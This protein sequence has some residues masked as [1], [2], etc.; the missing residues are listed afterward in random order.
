MLTHAVTF[1]QGTLLSFVLQYFLHKLLALLQMNLIFLILLNGFSVVNQNSNQIKSWWV[2]YRLEWPQEFCFFTSLASVW[3]Y[4]K[5]TDIAHK[6]SRIFSLNIAFYTLSKTF[7]GQAQYI[8]MHS[9][10]VMGSSVKRYNCFFKYNSLSCE[11][12][13]PL[14][15]EC[16]SCQLQEAQSLPFCTQ[17]SLG[18]GWVNSGFSLPSPFPF[19]L[20]LPW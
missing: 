6:Y 8:I 13:C 10:T 7:C 17:G 20:M 3:V 9:F 5:K 16:E 11:S 19:L 12:P 18:N 14:M 2:Y 4:V 15:T 1:I